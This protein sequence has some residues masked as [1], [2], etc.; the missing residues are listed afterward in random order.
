M[1]ITTQKSKKKLIIIL[2]IVAI[3]IIGGGT[4][5]A[6]VGKWGPFSSSESSKVNLK[7]ATKEQQETGEKIKQ[8]NA[9]N[10]VQNKPTGSD[11]P[12][13][14]VP[15]TNGKSTVSV[16]ITAANQNG[17]LLQVRS[18]IE[19]VANGMCTLTLSRP[20]ASV[21]TKT[22]DVQPL[23]S[24]STCQGFD[25]QT[26]GLSKGTWNMN[27]TFENSTIKGNASRTVDIQ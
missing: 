7:P 27:L 20:G 25:I 9:D 16:S 5:A 8:S 2:T 1:K 26:S 10:A 11:Q 19:T 21:I 15:Q 6:Y 23:A 14:P 22:A 13:A 12:P 24:S 4:V 17:T 3:V 18:L